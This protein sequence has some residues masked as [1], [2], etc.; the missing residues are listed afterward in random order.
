[1][2]TDMSIAGGAPRGNPDSH[3]EENADLVSSN[4]SILDYER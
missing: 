2:F 1:M 4:N 3:E